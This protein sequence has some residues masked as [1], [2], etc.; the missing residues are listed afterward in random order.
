[1]PAA[2]MS[3]PRSSAA[4]L[5]DLL[6][7]TIVVS[8]V[9]TGGLSCRSCS[10]RSCPVFYGVLFDLGWVC[11]GWEGIMRAILAGALVLALG[12]NAVA[13]R[14]STTL[15]H[16]DPSRE[17]PTLSGPETTLPSTSTFFTIHFT[18]TGTDS[19]SSNYADSVAAFADSTRQVLVS[20]LSWPDPPPD[21]GN[22]GDDTYDIYLLGLG[23]AASGYTQLDFY[24]AGGYPDDATSYVVIAVGMSPDELAA[25]VAHHVS[26]ACQYAYSANEF[27][28]WLEHTAGWLESIVFPDVTHWASV[29]GNYLNN[30]H[31]YL[32]VADGWTEHGGL[33]WPKFLA[34]STD[35]ADIVRRIWD[36][37]AQVA[38]NNTISATDDELLNVGQ[39]GI[40]A[41]FQV[42]TSWNYIS[43][44][45]DDGLHYGDGDLITGE[46]AIVATH[47]VYPDTGSSFFV[48]APFGLGANYVVFEN[49]GEGSRL[50]VSID[51]SDDESPWGAGIITHQQNDSYTFASVDLS[52]TTAEGD[53]IVADWS[54][55]QRVIL[56]VQNLRLWAEPQGVFSYVALT[57]P[58][59]PTA[60]TTLLAHVSGDWIELSWDEST[61]LDDDLVGYNV[62]RSTIPFLPDSLMTVIGN[63]V[64]DQDLGTPGVQWTDENSLGADVVGDPAT[65]HFYVVTA[66]DALALESPPSPRAGEFDFAMGDV[67]PAAPDER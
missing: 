37:C 57:L 5:A 12:Q 26:Q 17:R 6:N 60:P 15:Q 55:L 46:V 34:E 64:T 11:D 49:L 45:R 44:S 48:T 38:N 33:L 53:T 67:S 8:F 62:Y 23:P 14:Y 65:N 41:A 52:P 35:D 21:A 9:N 19:T 36:R 1:M 42:F 7:P 61:D 2:M 13:V 47:T 32:Y 66:V 16:R 18:T 31:K 10:A 20:E 43:G 22:G 28:A 4:I 63:A 54:D 39:P 40:E 25:T 59:A 56:I 24:V 3:I 50:Y 51:G 30:C 27:G 29:T 58:V